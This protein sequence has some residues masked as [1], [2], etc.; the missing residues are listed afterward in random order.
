LTNVADGISDTDGATY[1]QVRRVKEGVAMAMAMSGGALPDSKRY[2]VSV[3]F[4]TFD[5]QNAMGFSGQVRVTDHIVVSGG[6]GYGLEMKQVAA[7]AGI[8]FAW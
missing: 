2:S 7:R 4:G 6:L 1:G 5:R 8:Q 3:N